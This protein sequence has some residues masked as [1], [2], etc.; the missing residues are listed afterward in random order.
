MRKYYVVRDFVNHGVAYVELVLDENEVSIISLFN[1]KPDI[2]KQLF[3]EL[4]KMNRL[5]LD[6]TEF[7]LNEQLKVVECDS[8]SNNLA[9]HCYG[10][11][12]QENS[13]HRHIWMKDEKIEGSIHDFKDIEKYSSRE[14]EEYIGED[15]YVI[16]KNVL[17]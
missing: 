6:N 5:Q 12:D 16:L 15:A 8:H 17:N 2:S 14:Q 3:I 7:E 10:R 11:T 9:D 13:V 4:L 1:K